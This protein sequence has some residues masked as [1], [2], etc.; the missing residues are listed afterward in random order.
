MSSWVV[1]KAANPLPNPG[2][3]GPF[4]ASAVRGIS[5]DPIEQSQTAPGSPSA[6]GNGARGPLGVVRS[7]LSLRDPANIASADNGVLSGRSDPMRVFTISFCSMK[8]PL[9]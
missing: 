8:T 1:R 5:I 2:L 9:A 6:L 3:Q 7:R 4:F